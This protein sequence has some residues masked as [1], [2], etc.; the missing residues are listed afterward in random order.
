MSVR[1]HILSLIFVVPAFPKVPSEG[2]KLFSLHVKPLF[3]EKC[4]ACHGDDPEKIKSDF[5]MRTRESMLQGGEIFED[6]VLIP[7]QGHKSYLYILS[8]RAEEDLEMPPK[9]SDQLTE[10]ETGWIRQWID[11]GAPWPSDQRI[12]EIQEKYAEGEQV[13]T[14]KALSEDWQNRRYEPE[15]LWA[16]R[17]LKVEQIPEGK[18]PVDWFVN[19]KLEESGLKKSP[20]ATARELYRR[21]SF[22]LTGLPPLPKE[23]VN[24]E[25]D[26]KKSEKAL[27]IYAKKLMASPHYG[28]HFA[29]HWLDVARYADSGGFANDYSRPNAWRYRDYVV[30]A[31]NQD[32]PYNQFVMEQLAGDEINPKKTENL[33]ATGF[34]RMGPWEQTGMSVFKETRQLWLDDVTDSVG[35]AFL[36]H[37]MQCAKCHDHK[38]DPVPTRDYYGMMAVF[39]TTQFAE[40]NAPFLRFESRENF[41]SFTSLTR[42]K[43][44]SYEKQKSELQEKIKKLKIKETGSAKVGDNGLDPGDEASQSRIF[45]NL[46]RHKIELDRVQPFTHAVYTGKTI[47][48]KN[49][50]G[51]LDMPE[52]PWYKGYFDSDVIY[53]GGDAYSEGDAVIPSGL[54]AAESLGKMNT[55]PFP[56]GKGKRRLALAKWIVDKKNPL[57]A[58]VMV[59]RIWSWHFGRGLAGNPNN[60]G[61]TGELPT[62][63]GLLDYLANWFMKNGWSV[64]KLNHLILTSETYRRSSRHPDPESLAENDSKGQLYARFLP[65]RLAAEEM[66]DAMLRVS[67]EL[68]PRVGGIPVRPDINPEV[69]FQSR[70]IMGGTASVYEPDPL[71]EQRN[72][73]TLYAEKLRGL[74]DP[75]LE[76]FNQPGSDV[77]C[78]LRES[79]TVA[80]QALTLLNTEEVQDRALAFAARLLK[81]RNSDTAIIQRVFE[82][83]L[84]RPATKE[85]VDACVTRWKSAEKS[86]NEKRPIHSSFPNKIKRTV[87]AEKTGEPYDFWEHLPAAE[88]YQPDL[89]RSQTDGRTR[90]LA[91]VCLVLFNSNEFAYLD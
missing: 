84:S 26:F 39:S 40:R 33:V 17:P 34:L 8:T 87:M 83:A 49:V 51:R 14:S 22:G 48:R 90:G 3:A 66:R 81:E 24:F 69:A 68:N 57:T 9:Q 85:E 91:H 56:T 13:V 76:A 46:V 5:D 62:H 63:P 78:E 60:F 55:T 50:Q 12:A 4:M 7:G 64:K 2:E 42:A 59:N 31:F 30:R 29:R 27:S 77:S 43:I 38:F 75:F 74:R 19:R 53:N 72:R 86:E 67:G 10:E 21:L 52:D 11:E 6:E 70:Q 79:S 36:A 20:V 32:K 44:A 35:Q 28:E 23:V 45:K 1:V 37:A 25:K 41:D 15:K 58:R 80:P 18:H 82:L 61:G 54:S 47:V 65:R 16:Y 89:Q 73:R 71:P 88:S